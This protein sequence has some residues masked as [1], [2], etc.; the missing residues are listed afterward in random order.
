VQICSA[1]GAAQQA[2]TLNYDTLLNV[3]VF[4]LQHARMSF[5]GSISAVKAP[6]TD[7][8]CNRVAAQVWLR[9]ADVNHITNYCTL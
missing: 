3:G 5:F 8:C 7:V 1:R 6:V 4:M 2:G 9:I